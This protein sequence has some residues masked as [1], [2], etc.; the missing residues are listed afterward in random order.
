MYKILIWYKPNGLKWELFE[1]TEEEKDC[2][3]KEI[4]NAS[5]E[6]FIKIG[7]RYIRR[8][9]IYSFS[10]NKV[11]DYTWDIIR[12]IYKVDESETED[13]QIEYKFADDEHDEE[14]SI[15]AYNSLK[16]ISCDN[17]KNLDSG[18]EPY[19]VSNM[20]IGPEDIYNPGYAPMSWITG[21]AG[22]LYRCISE[23]ICGVKPTVSVLKLDPCFPDGWNNI[24]VTR[25]FR[26]NIYNITYIK[27]GEKFIVCDD[28]KV[29][30]L[31]IG[32]RGTQHN[33]VC[34]F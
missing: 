9:E 19:A 21:T 17:P 13:N 1:I 4:K 6:Q 29:D 18:V 20:Y 31:P 14:K 30:I 5:P 15:N 2:V 28:K 3:I 25:K 22:W 10:S 32:K 23:F 12:K 11:K 7:D 34:C 8:E 26:D 27:S 33:V 16:L 24:K